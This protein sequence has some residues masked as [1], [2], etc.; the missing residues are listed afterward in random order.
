MKSLLIDVSPKKRLSVSGFLLSFIKLFI[1]GEKEKV[2]LP[3]N[4]KSYSD[5][6]EKI[7]DFDNIIFAMPLYVDSVPSHLLPFLKKLEENAKDLNLHSNVYV[8]ANNGYIEGRQNEAL[9]QVMENFCLASG[10][11]WKGGLGIGGG[12]MLNVIRI[13]IPIQFIIMLINIAAATAVKG[14]PEY[15][16]TVLNFLSQVLVDFLLSIA[17]IYFTIKLA[18]CINKGKSFNKHYTRILLPSLIFILLADVFFIIIS[19]FK[20]GIFRGWLSRKKPTNPL[21]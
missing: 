14:Q 5:I 6:I 2:K 1:K 15:R 19:I 7:K 9:M 10:L 3:K 20:G 17:I 12:V 4:E 11:S 16:D 13:L 8:I 21:N 18:H